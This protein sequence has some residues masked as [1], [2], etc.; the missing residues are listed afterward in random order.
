MVDPDRTQGDGRVSAT[1]AEGPD[2]RRPYASPV[3]KRYGSVAL[4]TG[5]NM[6]GSFVDLMIPGTPAAMAPSDRRLKRNIVT[7]GKTAHGLSLYEYDIFDRRE[8]GVMADEVEHVVPAA[9]STRPDG[10]K[11]VDYA[12]LGIPRSTRVEARDEAS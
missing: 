9:V 5:S 11:E 10:Y 4:I 3:L 12:M 8:R 1:S 7:I 6:P 2:T